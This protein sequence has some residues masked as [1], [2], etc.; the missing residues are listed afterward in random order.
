MPDL[1]HKD[2]WDV[3]HHR[4]EG[5]NL[6]R[7]HS[8]AVAM[9]MRLEWDIGSDV[10]PCCRCFQ[11]DGHAADCELAAIIRPITRAP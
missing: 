9:L 5:S 10:C 11:S 6:A 1:D 2:A 8:V 3:A 4:R 7:C